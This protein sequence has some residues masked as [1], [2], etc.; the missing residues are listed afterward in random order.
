MFA[1]PQTST[2]NFESFLRMASVFSISCPIEE[3]AKRAF[4]LYGKRISSYCCKFS[5]MT[6]TAIDVGRDKF[7]DRA[8][9]H[10]LVKVLSPSATA[11][12]KNAVNTAPS[13]KQLC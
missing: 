6:S 3:K 9:I 11:D 12:V 7:I 10:A 1:H 8:D 4:K 5:R 13:L 2:L